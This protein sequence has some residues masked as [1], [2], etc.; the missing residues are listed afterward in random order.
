VL[1]LTCTVAR[2]LL[3][4]KH[5]EHETRETR[6]KEVLG[7]GG[8]LGKKIYFPIEKNQNQRD[9]LNYRLA[10]CLP[11][12]GTGVKRGSFGGSTKSGSKGKE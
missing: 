6:W 4:L 12:E 10:A 3:S 9:S 7:A 2:E 8:F 5:D 11:K 1:N